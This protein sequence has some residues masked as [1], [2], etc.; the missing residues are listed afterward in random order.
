M[1]VLQI[2]GDPL[3]KAAVAGLAIHWYSRSNDYA[4]LTDAYYKH[5]YPD[6][7]ILATEVGSFLSTLLSNL[8]ACDGWV[9]PLGPKLGD[10]S[11]G[12]HYLQDIINVENVHIVKFAS[13]I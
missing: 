10:W 8:Q 6:K 11:R 13:F 4:S 2:L 3:A 12:E 5:I 7:F 9:Q 1:F